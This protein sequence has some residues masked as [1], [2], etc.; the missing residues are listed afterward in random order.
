MFN[1]SRINLYSIYSSREVIEAHDNS[2]GDVEEVVDWS[3]EPLGDLSEAREDTVDDEN[4]E[5]IKKLFR[6]AQVHC[7]A[8]S[9][10]STFIEDLGK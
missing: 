10:A 2:E 7:Y 8:S 9:S 5:D 3:P 1:T 6:Q 4:D